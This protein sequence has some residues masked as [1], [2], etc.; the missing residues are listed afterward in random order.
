MIQK[1]LLTGTLLALPFAALADIGVDGARHL[2]LRTGFGA[3]PAQIAAFAPLSREAAVDKILAGVRA[4][5]VT[6][7]PGWTNEP[8]ERPSQPGLSE[9]QKKALQQERN[10]HAVALRS[11]WLTEMRDTPSPLTEKMTLFWHNHFVSS[12]EKVRSPQMMYRQNLLLRRYALGD[13]GQLLHA[14]ARDPAMMRY[15]D[16]VNNRQDQPNENFAREVMELFTLGEGHYSEQDI[17]EAARAFTGWGLDRAQEFI[18]RPRLRDDGDKVIFGQRGDFDGDDVVD[19]LLQQPSTAVFVTNKLWRNFVSPTPDAA[20]VN[21]LAADFR[22]SHYQIK[23]L[24]RALLLTPQFWRSQGLLVKSPVELTVGTLVTFDLRPPDW[25]VI[26]G[27]NR[28]L[29]QDVFAPPNVKGWPGGEAWI[30][31][32]TLLTRKQFLDRIARDAAPARDAFVQADGGMNEMAAREARINRFIN[33]GLNS[34]KLQPDEWAA[35]Y[36]VRNPDDAARLLL[37]VPPTNPLPPGESGAKAIAQLLLDP[38]Y[39]V[40]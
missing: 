8:F 39:Q 27:L 29:G 34:M 37:A 12:L 15:L 18:Y 24:M 26:A 7:P 36:G 5:A 6:P 40:E 10:Q 25:R 21:K 20:T 35:M 22:R 31:S 14:V 2:L 9:E 11:W 17:R 38:A 1:L 23:P 30:N 33:R 13:F 3:N 28:Q 19:L 4:Q 32:A 16:T